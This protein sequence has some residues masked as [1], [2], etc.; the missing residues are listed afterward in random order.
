MGEVVRIFHAFHNSIFHSIIRQI[1]RKPNVS[2]GN[3][4]HLL[5]LKKGREKHH[6]RNKINYILMYVYEL[7]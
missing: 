4:S 1:N 6:E 3:S 2:I 5:H 7:I